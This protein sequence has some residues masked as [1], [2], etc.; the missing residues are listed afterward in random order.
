ML[1][2]DLGKYL[3]SNE[4]RL[5]FVREINGL[6]TLLLL[7][8]TAYDEIALEK[9]LDTVIE[10]CAGTCDLEDD[11]SKAGLLAEAIRLLK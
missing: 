10:I 4:A 2:E 5:I 9:G 8:Q 11:C 1:V 7:F 3:G 6:S